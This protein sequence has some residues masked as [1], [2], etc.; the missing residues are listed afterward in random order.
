[1]KIVDAM[2]EFQRQAREKHCRVKLW[3]MTRKQAWQFYEE[4]AP[5]GGRLGRGPAEIYHDM[6]N[7]LNATF[8]LNTRIEVAAE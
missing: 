2:L 5:L 7:P 1:M 6:I 4:M 8:L 3:K